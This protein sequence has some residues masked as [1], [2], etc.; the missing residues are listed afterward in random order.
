MPLPTPAD[1]P[2]PS[3]FSLSSRTAL[4]T[5]GARGIGLAITH[6]LAEAGCSYIGITYSSSHSAPQIAAELSAQHAGTTVKAFKTDVRSRTSVASTFEEAKKEFGH[7]DI[8]VA[9]AG[10]T[11]HEDALGMSESQYR[12]V[13]GTNLDGAWWT[14]VEAG[15]VFKSQVEAGGRAGVLI[16]TGSVSAELVNLPQRQAAYNASKAGMVHL[17]RCLA[18]EWAEW[19][20]RV[21]SVSP[22]F[23]ETDSEFF[24]PFLLGW[25]GMCGVLED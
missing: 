6:A 10:I 8:V 3:L 16:F 12:D 5:G 18:V 15:R 17:A 19:G 2:T 1:A 9:N 14:A 13:M 24:R 21:N 23:I 7:L 22:G 4:I 25:E 11:I 20:G